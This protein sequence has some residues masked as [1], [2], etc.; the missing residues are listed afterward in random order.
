MRTAH[1]KLALT[2]LCYSAFPQ[3]HTIDMKTPPA[4]LSGLPATIEIT[5][6]FS[7][8]NSHS[9]TYPVENLPGIDSITIKNGQPLTIT[10]IFPESGSTRIK[11]PGLNY[12]K[13]VLVLPA[14]L[15]I[16]PPV[17]AILLAFLTRQVLLA[18]FFGILTGATLMHG[19][20]PVAG[21]LY[22]LSTY[23]VKS[24][25]EP[26]KMSILIFSLALGGM[27]GVLSRMGGLQTLVDKITPYAS[28]P[29]YGQLVTWLLGLLI[30]FDDYANTLIGGNTMRPLTDK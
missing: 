21:F 23:I 20:N 25:A 11:L 6:T 13:S 8:N 15:S 17:L 2:L 7:G 14:W 27:V 3:T 10:T 12:E 19:Y 9:L 1:L 5:V 30:F 22:G 24:A 28:K 18:L 4:V 16:L 26:D 29:R